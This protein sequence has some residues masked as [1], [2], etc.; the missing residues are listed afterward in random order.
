MKSYQEALIQ[1][2]VR[3]AGM[4]SIDSVSSEDKQDMSYTAIFEVYPEIEEL[5]IPAPDFDDHL[6]ACGRRC[7]AW[8]LRAPGFLPNP[9]GAL[10]ARNSVLK[11]RATLEYLARGETPPLDE[12]LVDPNRGMPSPPV[13]EYYRSWYPRLYRENESNWRALS[14]LLVVSG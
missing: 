14:A 4:P 6:A 2:K 7:A 12:L 3:P 11:T 10:N 1:E 8:R 5:E 13:D 9:D